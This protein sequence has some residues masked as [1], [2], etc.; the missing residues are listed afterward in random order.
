MHA[1]YL[2]LISAV[3]MLT[4]LSISINMVTIPGKP[5]V[6]RTPTSYTGAMATIDPCSDDTNGTMGTC[7]G[8]PTPYVPR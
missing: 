6:Y 4:T 2:L 3:N 1:I 5:A 7:N 8:S